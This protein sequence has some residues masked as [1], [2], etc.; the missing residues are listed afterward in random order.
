MKP[1]YS[2]SEAAHW[3]GI[4]KSTLI[5]AVRR[6]EFHP[7]FVTPG[8]HLRFT[9]HELEQIRRHLRIDAARRRR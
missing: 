9:I 6:G 2:T 1:A 3:L 8:R 5:R 4:S 7:A